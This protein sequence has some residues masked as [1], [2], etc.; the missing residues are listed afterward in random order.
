MQLMY[1][2]VCRF[3]QCVCLSGS[4]ITVTRWKYSLSRIQHCSVR[5][6]SEWCLLEELLLFTSLSTSH[7]GT[8]P[9]LETYCAA[10]PIGRVGGSKDIQAA[11]VLALPTAPVMP[12]MSKRA[13]AACLP[14]V[15]AAPAFSSPTC[16]EA[17]PAMPELV[18][19][20]AAGVRTGARQ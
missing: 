1:C 8:L 10:L 2:T 3:C 16:G 13:L 6:S 18:D 12:W 15:N 20:V 19:G 7:I 14:K 17:C 11:C 4:D 9:T 5:S